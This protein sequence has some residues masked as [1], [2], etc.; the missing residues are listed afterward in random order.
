MTKNY[1]SVVTRLLK[2]STISSKQEVTSYNTKK[3]TYLSFLTVFVMLFSFAFSQA[4]SISNYAF[5]SANNA[6]LENLTTGATSILTGNQDDVATTI[7]TIGFDFYFM[8]NKYTHF[9]ANSN[10]QIRLHASATETAI[11]GGGVSSYVANTV[12]LAPMAGDN[13]VNDGIKMKLIGTA[14][15]RKLVVE[16]T[17]FYAQYNNITNAGNM[18]LSLNETSNVIDFIYG[19]IYNSTTS[20]QSRSIFISSGN[21][22]TA[23]GHVLVGAI[24]TFTAATTPVTNA[25]AASTVTTGVASPL[26]ANLGSSANGS[27]LIYTFTPFVGNPNPPIT[28]TTTAVSQ[29]ATTVNWV[30]NSTNEGY[31]T[32]GRSTSASG[33][34]I[35]VGNVNSTTGNSIGTSY[36]YTNTGLVENTTYYYEIK[37]QNESGGKSSAL[38][39]SEI[40][41]SAGNVSAIAT[42][43]W[44]ETSTW[45]TGL[46]P[47][48]TDNV[49][50]PTGLIVTQDVTAAAAYSLLVQ[51]DLIYTAITARI[52]TVTTN[53]TVAIGG[54][55]KSAATGTV[56]THS[57]VVGGNLTNNGTIDFSTNT[58]TA[59]ATITFN[60]AGN[61]NFTLGTT[62]ITNLRNSAGITLNKGTNITNILTFS[63][64][65]TLTV[66]GA[67][68]LGFM[69][70]TNGLLKLDGTNT[71]NNP[72]FATNG[73]SIAATAGYWQNNPNA[74]VI[75][76]GG[77]PTITGLFRLSSGT[78]N[79]GTG[80]GNSMGFGT[81]STII[82]EGGIINAASRFGTTGSTTLINYTQ[83][84]GVINV[85]LVGNTST[86]LASFDLGTNAASVINFT[87]GTVNVVLTNTAASGPRDVRGTSVFTPNY[88]GNGMINFGTATSGATPL[89]YY[90]SGAVPA[91]TISTT[92]AIH[93][94][95]VA[96]ANTQSFGN[97]TI[98][99]GSTFNL[100]GFQFILRGTNVINNGT[101]TGTTTGSS[102]YFFAGT[103][104][105]SYSGSGVCTAGL[106]SLSIDTG[107][108]TFTI[109][110]ASSGLNPLRVNMFSGNIIN[111]N[112]ITIGT[113]LALST[114]I[115]TGATAST[116]PGGSFDVSPTWN[117]GTGTHTLL[118]SQESV[119]RISGFEV[120]PTR[121][122][123]AL[124]VDNTN[125]VT[126]TGGDLTTINTL[127]LTN[128]IV[129]TGVNTLTV[130][131]I[132]TVGTLTGGSATAYVN[133]SLSRSIANAN[134]N[135]TYVTFPIGK[136]G[137][138]TP[139]ALAPATTSIALFKA[140]SFGSNTGTS[141]ASIIGLSTTR[142]FQALPVSGTFT[143]INV[144]LADASI[145]STNIPVQ[146]PTAAGSY[147]AAF[148]SV[149]TYT[150]GTPNTIQSNFPATSANYTGFLSFANSNACS[151]TPA[152]GN[153]VASSTSICFGESVTL[154]LQNTTNGSGVTYQWKSSL[155]GTT[156]STLVG[157]TNSTL[158]VSPTEV[159]Y[160]ICDVTCSTGPSTGTSV[161]VQVTFTNSITA[162][163]PGTRCGTGTVDLVA[164]PNTGASVN[165]YAAQTGGSLLGSGTTFTTPSITATTTYYASANTATPGNAT[166][167]TGTALTGS[168]SQNSIFC[169]YWATGWRQ[170]VYTSAELS[171][172]GLSAG[173][174]TSLTF[175]IA[176]LPNPATVNNFAIQLGS[177]TNSTL[178]AFTTTG[179]SSAFGP[180]NYTP[181]LGLNTITLSTPYNWDGVS[182]ILIDIREDGQYASA[183]S[184]TYVTT[185]ATN[186][187]VHGYA[188]G[189]TPNPAY[190]TSSPT[191]TA[192]NT[193]PNVIFNGQVAC[194][195]I[196]VPVIATV[197]SPPALTLS[198]ATTTICE[199]DTS[200]SVT[201]TSVIGDYNTY[202]W[203]PSTGVTGNETTGWTFNPSVTTMYTLTATQTSGSLCSTTAN[204]TVTVN[205]RPS[206]MTVADATVCVDAIQSL[207]LSGGTIGVEGKVG[208]GTSTNTAST[209]FR[210]FYGGS[211]TQALYT[212]SELTAL[213][214]VAGQNINTIGYVALSGTPL[215]LND[216]TINAGFVASS[217]LGSSFIAGAT[218]VVLAPVNYT[219]TTGTGN[220]DFTLSTP[221]TWDG[222]SNLLI[223]TCFNNNN[224]GGASANSISLESTIVASGLNLYRSQD[225]TVDVCSNTATTTSTTT[226]PNLRISSIESA[227]TTWS[228]VNNL[229]T[230]AAATLAY[231]ANSNAT[232]VYFK[233]STAAAATTYTITS[234]TSLGCFRTTTAN[235]TV[236]ALTSNST[237]ISACDS[238]TWAEN[239]MTYT[240]SGTYTSVTGCN[241]ETL[242]LTIT[243]GSSLPNEVV[244][245]CD[246]YTWA[247]NGTVYTTGGTYTSTTNCVTRTLNLTINASSTLPNEVVAACD[248]YTWAA[249]G[250]VYTTGGTYTSTTN[251]VTST[252]DLTINASP[253]NATT[254]SGDTLSATETGATYQW[255]LCDGSFTPI[256]GAT[257][258]SYLVTAIGSYAVDIT[259]NGCTVRSACVNV[260]ALGNATFD[261]TKLS[262]YPNPVLDMFTV[263]YS[264]NITSIDVYDL[265]GRR[266]KNST[267]NNTE[268]TL[269]MSDL[270]ASVY[271]V[272]VFTEGK[273]SEFKI[274]K[275]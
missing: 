245:A 46:V 268:V 49:T 217:T 64:G 87:A 97:V 127:A 129:S 63:P 110:T 225:N 143:D 92:S 112:K 22:A 43:L 135:T 155:D 77:S 179:L 6:S 58:N 159:T 35:I 222:V 246:T 257:S 89:T 247:A 235:V 154:S 272:K 204:F 192:S 16:W 180:V 177:T 145:S 7:Q 120:N 168:T 250:T 34:F 233:S 29:I 91:F 220:L 101:L 210:G 30:D 106:L 130:G 261:L 256:S 33:P 69:V 223:E 80:T 39:G 24:P 132:T 1:D 62:S 60:T 165:W 243:T 18:Q 273:S 121:I 115:Q 157:E 185:T 244:S 242:N 59:G 27:R 14:P 119:A 216:F 202:V 25:F 21:T 26:I 207:V 215:V 184:Q 193:R 142:R 50:I 31:F 162:T 56:T 175:N 84:G 61:A 114:A 72:L 211:K 116:N 96:A 94:L 104:P 54:S 90:V 134:A 76:L 153:T 213:G 198:A 99:T 218:N 214:M 100:N 52:L 181:V 137:I 12:T 194:S 266:V 139:I 19:E 11:S 265:S 227:N 221:L 20:S 128:G 88:V 188:S 252:L 232:T 249:N 171:A 169:N 126:I 176:S 259:K 199:S 201:I 3:R 224:G 124:S 36:G 85:N 5:S 125:G 274:V 271:V 108:N 219:P 40:T 191:A 75:G 230:D 23:S 254:Q 229:Y 231:V 71:F 150:A 141:D 95:S 182:N 68:A 117:L 78:F 131:N 239:G 205:P 174:I 269:Y 98:P 270:A 86:T 118:Y 263:R 164:T 161:A 103:S 237:T 275:K 189:T 228:P 190:Y 258:Q 264:E 203:S 102:L 10:G 47:T 55:I 111:S 267:S 240:A 53:T 147:S 66:Q 146:A 156:Y 212:A 148:G 65:G 209:P 138:Y 149:A 17:Q 241:T 234:T 195:S 136:S 206:I 4:Q 248:T 48:A 8:G 105:Q 200:T 70:I 45:S 109:D 42:G 170:M 32:I 172:A 253:S 260:T 93:N 186:T 79:I 140:E 167:G 107:V 226:R 83:T 133:G 152:P 158:T 197:S 173:N 144:R 113:G 187:V 73:Y 67:N 236:N 81:N 208:S 238:Y 44:S 74:T 2:S 196:R 123:N 183:N 51:G 41:L 28:F 57:L 163:T 251:C 178:T 151:G 122:V 9:S 166:I 160:Y 37:A 15:N 262:Y 255:L 82:I 13:E 38:T